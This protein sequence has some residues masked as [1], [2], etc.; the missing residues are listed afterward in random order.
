MN[1][2]QKQNLELLAG[3]FDEWLAAINMAEKTQISYRHDIKEFFHWVIENLPL[4]AI[5]EITPAHLYQYQIALYNYEREDK[6]RLAVKTQSNKLA[7]IKKFFSWLVEIQ[8]LAYD[9]AAGLKLPK[10]RRALPV[11]LTKTEARQLIE[12]I[13][14]GEPMGIRDRAIIEML[15]STGMR[16]GELLALTIYDVNLAAGTITIKQAKNN[17]SRVVPITTSVGATLRQYLGEVRPK[18]VKA[19]GAGELFVSMRSGRGLDD[20]DIIYIV[21]RAAERAGIKKHI[22]PHTLRHSCATHLLKGKADIRQIQRLLGHQRLSTTE[23]YARVEVSDLR[24][25]LERCHP[26]EKKRCSKR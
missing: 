19:K 25:V 6:G 4:N 23:I 15:Y 7:A 9:P 5:Q 10:C 16:K 13:P 20:K 3:R 8:Q 11:V 18:L 12:A 22:S 21:R 26:R 14:E 1:D 2:E 17:S 24:K